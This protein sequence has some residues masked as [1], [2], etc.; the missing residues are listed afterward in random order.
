[1]R[2][3]RHTNGRFFLICHLFSSVFLGF[4]LL[5]LR[6]RRHGVRAVPLLAL[7]L[8][9]AWTTILAGV[10]SLV[11]LPFLLGRA[12]FALLHLPPE[13]THDTANF[14]VGL[15]VLKVRACPSCSIFLS[16]CLALPACLSACLSVLLSVFLFA[17]LSFCLSV[18]LLFLVDCLSV[19]LSCYACLSA[20]LS[21]SISLHE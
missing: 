10:L 1:M 16:A 8:A 3:E 5:L 20:C 6:R 2:K 7:L 12:V 9:M 11:L 14:S 18:C 13:W 4:F 21:G 17:C 15:T 19:G